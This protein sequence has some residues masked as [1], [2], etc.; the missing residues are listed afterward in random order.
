MSTLLGKGTTKKSGANFPTA[1]DFL[2]FFNEKVDA[3]RRATGGGRPESEL[4]H[5]IAVR[6]FVSP[7]TIDEIRNVISGTPS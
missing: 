2:D 4:P 7:Y 6:K 1:Q 3:V 5:A